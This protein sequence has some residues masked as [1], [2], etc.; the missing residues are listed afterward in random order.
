VYLLN[1]SDEYYSNGF[2]LNYRFVSK[3]FDTTQLVKEIV[4]I[5]L[6]HKFFTPDGLLDSQIKNLDRPYAGVLYAGIYKAKFKNASTR[7]NYGVMLGVTG[8]ASGAEALQIWYHNAVGFHRPAGWQHQIKNAL[9]LNFNTVHNKQFTLKEGNVDLITS[10]SGMVGTGFVNLKQNFDLRFGVLADLNRSSF[11]NAVIGKGSR[12]FKR[13][14]YVVLG[15]GL[16]YVHH[17]ITVSGSLFNDDSPHV[18][19]LMPWLSSFR[20]GW[21][22]SSKG[23]TFKMNFHWFTKEVRTA[24]N[25]SYISLD[26]AFRLKK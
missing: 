25:H 11:V 21:T 22:T 5:E 9:V 6:S 8:K 3:R 16:S 7:F 12:D 17:D 1:G 10:S 2:L 4:S 18:S 23:F 24:R 19:R 15:Y 26:F 20:V 13:E 14:R